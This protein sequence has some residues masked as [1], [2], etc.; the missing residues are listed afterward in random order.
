MCFFCGFQCNFHVGRG[1]FQIDLFPQVLSP[2]SLF[3]SLVFR[4]CYMLHPTLSSLFD[5]TKNIVN[6][7]N[8]EASR[9]GNLTCPPLLRPPLGQKK[10]I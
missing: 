8:H 2:K 10:D 6:S 9:H 1:T 4:T 7:E 3:I 5:H